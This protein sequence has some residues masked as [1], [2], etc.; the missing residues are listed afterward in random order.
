MAPGAVIFCAIATVVCGIAYLVYFTP[1]IIALARRHQNAGAIAWLNGLAGWTFVG[2]VIAFVWAWTAIPKTQ[3]HV[4]TTRVAAYVLTVYFLTNAGSVLLLYTFV[5]PA[6]ESARNDATP[7]I[8]A[9]PGPTVL[10]RDAIENDDAEARRKAASE[11]A[12]RKFE[13]E[14]PNEAARQRFGGLLGNAQNL[15]KAGMYSDAEKPLR[16]IINGAPGTEIAAEATQVLESIS[17]DHRTRDKYGP[18][19][20]NAKRLIE[21]KQFVAAEQSLRQII[22]EAPLTSVSMEARRLLRSLPSK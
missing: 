15:I 5:Y 10:Q 11:A 18:Q 2:W 22:D 1:T 6:Y 4:S 13:E 17:L 14:H 20:D 12:Q 3:T 8:N 9:D 19:L 7:V 21:A 16:R